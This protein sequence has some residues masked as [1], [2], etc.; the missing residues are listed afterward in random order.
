MSVSPTEDE[1]I[2]AL[3]FEG[4]IKCVTPSGFTIISNLTNNRRPQS[5]AFSPGGHASRAF[6]HCYFKSRVYT[7]A[8]APLPFLSHL[9]HRFYFVTTSLLI[10]TSVASFGLSS[11]ARQY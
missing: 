9:N 6:Q 5:R 8:R 4:V 2:V 7:V 3:D 10:A 11:L 1:L